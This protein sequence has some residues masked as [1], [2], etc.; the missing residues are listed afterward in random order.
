MSEL[1]ERLDR[2]RERIQAPDFLEGRGLSNE[3]NIQIFCYDPKDELAVRH[4]VEKITADQSMSCR[5]IECDLYRAFIDICNELDIT[6]S[7]PEM[8]EA[9]GS[10]YL[11]E[12][13]HS[14]IGET[15]FIAKIQEITGQT[16]IGDV[17]LLTGIGDVF[18]F[19]RV[20]KIL[21]AMQPY[22]PDA[23]ILVLYPGSFDGSSLK[24]FDKLSPNPYYRAFN[25]L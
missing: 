21:E 8:E 4:F 25:V 15:E 16:G 5:L 13:L 20:H 1:R 17:I 24:L 10:D 14:T 2:L 23:P 3:V 9:D 11:L 18:P 12:Q 6:D 22:F 7:I 19:M